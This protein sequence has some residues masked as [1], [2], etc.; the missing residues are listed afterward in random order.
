[1]I[2]LGGAFVMPGFN[3]AHVHL[4]S[5]GFEKLNVDLAAVKSLEEMKRRIAERVKNCGA[6]E[7]IKGRGWD[8]TKWK[9]KHSDTRDLDAVTRR[10]SGHLYRC[11]WAHRCR[12]YGRVEGFWNQQETRDPKGW[13]LIET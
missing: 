13:R 3:D 1:V 7:W 10:S 6:G 8:H 12:Q 9:S 5:G 4:A 2:D 11:R